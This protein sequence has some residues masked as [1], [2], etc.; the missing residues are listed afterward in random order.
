[1]EYPKLIHIDAFPVEHAGQKVVG[2]RD[3]SSM[4]DKIVV[5]PPPVFFIVSLFDGKHSLLDIK[6]EYMRKYGQMIFT[7]RLEEIIHYLDDHYLLES[8]K[9][10]AYRKQVEDE[11]RA[12]DRRP[13]VFAGKSYESDPEKLIQQM[14]SFFASPEG[15]GEALPGQREKFVKGIVAPH[16]DFHRGGPCYAWA[17]KEL[18][19]SPAPDLFIVLGTVHAPTKNPFVLTRK[20]FETPLGAIHTNGDMV[21]SLEKKLHVNLFDDEIVHKTEHT[22]EFQLVFLSYLYREK[23]PFTV[24]PIL[25]GSFYDVIAEDVPLEEKPHVSDF[26]C[27]L[28]ETVSECGNKT[29]F[30]ASAD[31]AHVGLRFGDST[32]PSPASLQQIEREDR[33]MLAYVEN[34]DADGFFDFVRREKDSRKICGLPPIYALLKLM[35]AKEGKLLNYQ[36]SVEPNGS[37]VVSFASMVFTQ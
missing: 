26:V 5:V 6:A 34:M 19:Q 24:V 11:F 29:C 17:Y 36:Q 4:S 33:N 32:P 28:R 13:A 8:E 21:E 12:T 1:M 22:I 18:A 30:V 37:S 35:D 16:I 10:D 23:S 3:P 25:C 31:L 27:A 20:N 2:L 9:Y 7:E 15:P 14:D